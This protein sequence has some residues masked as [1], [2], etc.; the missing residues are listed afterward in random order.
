MKRILLFSLL[1]LFVFSIQAQTA[2]WKQLHMGNRAFCAGRFDQ[3]E[4]YYR[5][6]LVQSPN[7][8]R[9]YFNL[10]DTYLAKKNPNAAMLQFKQAIRFEKNPQIKSMAYHNMGY[11][12]QKTALNAPI[13][14]RQQLL[15]QAIDN[16]KNALR[17]NPN[18]EHSRYNL[19]LCQR[20]L[21]KN[22]HSEKQNGR[23]H[24]NQK[25]KKDKQQQQ[26]RQNQQNQQGQSQ[27]Q[28]DQQ[29]QQLLNLARQSE[30]QTRDKVN[31]IQMRKRN[32]GKNW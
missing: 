2:G 22:N 5:K 9:A 23:Q 6:A 19:A 4:V 25:T 27:Q 30:Q 3:A 28:S 26:K 1:L 10:G 29:L 7:N 21:K 32:R 20:Q 12:N 13:M 15:Q 14:Q 8:A 24:K 17:L 18:S 31:K 16:Y 11:I